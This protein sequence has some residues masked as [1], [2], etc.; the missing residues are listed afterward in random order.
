[1]KSP[2][3][4]QK[5]KKYLPMNQTTKSPIAT[6][7]VVLLLIAVAVAIIGTVVWAILRIATD[8]GQLM[9]LPAE[10]A[11][12]VAQ[13]RACNPGYSLFVLDNRI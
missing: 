13:W 9:A 10:R 8:A 7:V 11:A 1:M 3:R 2:K 4:E 12:V 5:R 6:I